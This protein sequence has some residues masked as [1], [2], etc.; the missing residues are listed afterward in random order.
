MLQQRVP[1][2][3]LVW[4]PRQVRQMVPS[5]TEPEF[6]D[7]ILKKLP[8]R[9][10]PVQKNRERHIFLHIQDWNQIIK[11][12]DESDLSSSENSQPGLV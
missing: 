12:I 6:F 9:I 3:V 8:I 5:F 1:L 7:Q 11:L 10:F 2:Q 4:V